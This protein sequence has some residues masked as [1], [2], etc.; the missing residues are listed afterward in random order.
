MTPRTLPG[1]PYPLGA[2]PGE[3]GTNFAVAAAAD[4]V[5]LCLFDGNTETQVPLPERDGEVWHGF[6]PGVGPGQAYG[7]RTTGPYRPRDGVRCNPA[8]LLL[9]PYARA[10]EGE[11]R[12]GAEVLGY[13]VGDPEA[14]STL[15]S[16]GHVP[17]SLVVP[18]AHDWRHPR[19]RR[20]YPDT[21]IYEVHVKGFTQTH[22]ALPEDIRGTYAGLA[23]D[24]VVEHLVD[25][26][27][28]AVELLPVHHFVPE[29]FLVDRGLTNYWGYN[30]IGFF[31]PHA[32]YS[33]AVR[34]GRP[35]GQVAEFRSM[36]DTLHGA[37]LEVI[38]DVVFNHTAE[39]NHLGPTLCH[40]GL[41]NAAY[42]RLV[43][44]DPRYYFDTTGVGNSLNADNPFSLR[45][46]MDSLRYWLTEM[47]VDGFRFDLAPTLAREDGGFDRMA[48]FFDLVFQDPVIS[49]AK[50]IAEPWDVG[51]DGYD[52]GRF[53]AQWSEW[54]GSYRDVMRDFWRSRD[55]LLDDFARRLCG[56]SDLFGNS[57][58]RPTASVNLITVHDGFTLTD[59]VSYNE[60]HNE[61][62]G[63]SNRDGNPDNRSWN[64]GAE[65]P[66]TDTAVL[67]LRARQRRAFLTTLMLSF[68]VP[69]LLGGDELGRTQRGNNNAYCQDNAISWF[70]WADTDKQLL[71]FTRRLIALRREHPVFRRRRFL[72]GV[73]A[74]ELQWFT[75]SGTRMTVADW[76][77]PGS[78]AVALYLDGADDPDRAEDGTPLFDDD[79]LILVNGWWEQ[80]AFAIPPTRAGQSW[81]P[82]IDTYEPTGLSVA[83]PV[84]AG[85]HLTVRSRSLFV[86]RGLTT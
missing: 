67:D 16:A 33:A 22:P 10:I 34:A 83:P 86:L 71:E 4:G 56:S 12:P 46:I 64:C 15:D 44:D 85:E 73:A 51:P 20:S 29:A 52:L 84:V 32:G 2:T 6:L 74:E 9:D 72:T 61:A 43:P 25:L 39:G 5:L 8:K 41:H 80:L 68:G 76:D 36:V 81:V 21:I 54:N 19:P 66:T 37:G 13:A 60:K 49:R 63:E 75:P 28:T 3:G 82:V 27:V 48:A 57:G 38:L 50:L 31:A 70:D 7:Y 18:A 69:L 79:F 77:D 65:G 42:Y 1:K 53:P 23:H 14:P 59:L 24:A 35:G 30:T 47:G 58:R 17:R 45:L 62:N 11:V 40:R 26:G 55:G 78:R